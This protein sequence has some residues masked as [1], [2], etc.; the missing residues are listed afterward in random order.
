LNWVKLAS[1]SA[2]AIAA[3]VA[4][5]SSYRHIVEV[6]SNAGETIEVASVIP[7][8]IDGLIV[9]GTMAMIEDRRSGRRPRLSARVALGFGVVATLCANIASAQPHVTARLVAAVPAVAFLLAVEVLA[10]AGKPVAQEPADPEPVAVPV[11]P[12]PMPVFLP[13]P[14]APDEPAVDVPAGAPG[15]D[16]AAVQPVRQD[17]RSAQEVETVVRAIRLAEPRLSQRRIAAAAMTSP[18]TVRRILG[19]ARD[20]GQKPAEQSING[21]KVLEDAPV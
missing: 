6:A 4:G 16:E 13:P 9:V 11:K 3:G 19:P 18:T 15:P 7:L 8:S 2:A 20:A 12:P 5:F 14:A 21:A 17:L 1:R 10:R